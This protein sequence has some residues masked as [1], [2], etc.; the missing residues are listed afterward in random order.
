MTRGWDRRGGLTVRE[1]AALAEIGPA[2]L[3]R[4]RARGTRRSPPWQALARLARPARSGGGRSSPRPQR[5]PPA[6]RA[7]TRP[8]SSCSTARTPGRRTGPGQA[9]TGPGWPGSSS[10]EFLD[11]PGAADRDGRAP[12]PGRAGLAARRLQRFPA[13]GHVQPA[14]P[15]PARLRHR[16][17]RR[18]HRARRPRC[19]TAGVTAARSA[20]A[21]TSCPACWARRC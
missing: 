17:R 4:S 20:T 3:R 19:W 7:R 13:P 10:K 11:R 1:A 15:G 18:R 14:A 8:G 6:G 16:G 5:C 9:G 21:S 12:V 2:G